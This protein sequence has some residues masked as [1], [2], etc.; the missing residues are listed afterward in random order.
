MTKSIKEL[1]SSLA[2]T[3]KKFQLETKVKVWKMGGLSRAE[4]TR[5]VAERKRREAGIKPRKFTGLSLRTMTRPEYDR[6][7]RKLKNEKTA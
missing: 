3:L 4:Y 2:G 6:A 7:L 5:Q 1:A